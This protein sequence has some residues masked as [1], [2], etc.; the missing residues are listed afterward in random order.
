MI[1]G[2]WRRTI[3]IP[4]KSRY[5][6]LLF[7]AKR[8]TSDSFPVQFPSPSGQYWDCMAGSAPKPRVGHPYAGVRLKRLRIVLSHKWKTQ[9][10]RGRGAV[11]LP[12]SG[13]VQYR[14]ATSVCQ[15]Q[16]KL[17]Y[18]TDRIPTQ[19]AFAFLLLLVDKLCQVLCSRS[20][21]R[22]SLTKNITSR[23]N[24]VKWRLRTKFKR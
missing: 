1:E 6:N 11:P 7:C 23:V 4:H 9:Q 17:R 15:V 16:Y 3:F 12:R 2:W 5:A 8:Y 19:A 18:G 10:T 22:E 20:V 13:S 14:I 24:S 21:L